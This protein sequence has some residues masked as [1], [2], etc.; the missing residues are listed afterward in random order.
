MKWTKKAFLGF[1]VL[2]LIGVFGL[3]RL[4][5]LNTTP[6]APANFSWI[7]KVEIYGLGVLMSALAYCVQRSSRMQSREP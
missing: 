7:N 5:N 6:I 1:M 2:S 3:H 4:H